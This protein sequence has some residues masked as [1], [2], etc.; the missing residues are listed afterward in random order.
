MTIRLHALLRKEEKEPTKHNKP[1]RPFDSVPFQEA[2]FPLNWSER[3]KNVAININI[4]YA[5]ILEYLDNLQS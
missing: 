2:I 5:N 3:N 1:K 4:I